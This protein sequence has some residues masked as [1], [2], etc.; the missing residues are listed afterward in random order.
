MNVKFIIL[1]FICLLI[2]DI[3]LSQ[4]GWFPL[5]SGTTNGLKS[6]L[7]V[8]SQTGFV[9]GENNTLLKTMNG[10]NNWQTK[11][12]SSDTTLN[13]LFFIDQNTGWSAGSLGTIYKTT[14]CGDNWMSQSL[15]DSFPIW[16]IFFANDN[17]G[18]MCPGAV[19]KTTNGGN[20]WNL[21]NCPGGNRTLF[22]VNPTTGF[23]AGFF[24]MVYKTTDAGNNWI[25]CSSEV[26]Y[27]LYIYSLSF[28]NNDIGYGSEFTFMIKTTNGGNNWFDLVE[29]PQMLTWSI[30]F[31]SAN[32]GWGVGQY[33]GSSHKGVMKTTNGGVNW[34]ATDLGS[35]GQLYSVYFIDSNTGWTAGDY[36]QIYKTTNGGEPIGIKKTSSEVPLGFIL[37]QNYPNPFNPV[38]TIKFDIAFSPLYE[39]GAGG[40]VTLKVY[41][42]LGR[43]I[44]VLINE[45]LAPASNA[46]TWDASNYPSGVYFYKLSSG[47]YTETRKMVLIK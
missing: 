8:N 14:N 40:F 15:L 27:R 18:W 7:F 10:G 9:C 41:D 2:S 26:G 43:E 33:L 46:L 3:S 32:T 38:T 34:N 29:Y 19:F 12:P 5:N 39:R 30:F 45:D 24:G 6:V 20:N 37:Y 42:I 11:L 1:S 28:P 44:A 35:N 22:F 21:Q 4:S 23:A 25:Y 36:G 47:N 31:A 13:T 16:S 17:T